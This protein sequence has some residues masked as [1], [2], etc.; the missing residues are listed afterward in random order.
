MPACYDGSFSA[1]L[2]DKVRRLETA[3]GPRIIVVGGS[4]VAFGVDS[5]LLEQ[6]FPGYTAVNFGVYAALGTDLML[7]LSDGMFRPGDLVILSPEQQRQTLSCYFNGEMT[8][9]AADGQFG[10]LLGLDPAHAGAL[11]G[12]FPV[13]AAR[14][15]RYFLTGET[16]QPEGVYRRLSFDE[17]GD[18]R[19]DCTSNRMPGGWDPAMTVLLTGDVWQAEWLDKV[20]RW[21]ADAAAQGASVYYRF[22]PMNAAAVQGDADACY[23]VLSRQLDFP[24]LGDPNAS[25]MD[26]CWFYDTN[27]HLNE[28]GRQ[29]NTR[30]MV[31]DIKAVLGD[32]SPTTIPIPTPPP[33][34]AAPLET[35]L[36]GDLDC[37]VM[38]T[39]GA[40]VCITGVTEQARTKTTLTIPA[41][42]DGLPVT[43]LADGLFE[44]C[45][46]LRTI[47]LPF[48]DPASCAPGADLL[49]G[50]QAVLQVP[51]GAADRY[52]LSYAWAPYASRI[53]ES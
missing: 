37:F 45:P 31:R 6:Q 17:Y 25:V 39:V 1:A 43:A 3:Q 21:A 12:Q 40:S 27:F 15:A 22:C 18:I 51:A 35:G 32:S 53:R 50:T 10:L 26:P 34:S 14:K 41:S 33:F 30:C 28:A 7:E 38:E 23:E 8:W 24:I 13:F 36:Q 48:E 20:N 46:M 9:Q 16:P 5:A 4:S 11:A 49:R 44:Q 52:R 29:L 47:V 19:A 42:R 2:G